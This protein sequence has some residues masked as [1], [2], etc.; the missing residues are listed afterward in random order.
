MGGSCSRPLFL[1]WQPYCAAVDVCGFIEGKTLLD[2][3]YFNT[4]TELYLPF[5]IYGIEHVFNAIY[6]DFTPIGPSAKPQLI[7]KA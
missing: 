1:A 2:Y 4:S 6:R 3:V 7:P 5:Y